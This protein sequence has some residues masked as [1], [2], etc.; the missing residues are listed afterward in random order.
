MCSV[1]CGSQNPVSWR[2]LQSSPLISQPPKGRKGHCSEKREELSSAV[3]SKPGKV[4]LTK[5]QK[6][7]RVWSARLQGE[8]STSREKL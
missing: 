1:G 5:S 3:L 7:G 6:R 2:L 4:I 8:N